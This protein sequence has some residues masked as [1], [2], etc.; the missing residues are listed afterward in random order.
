MQ[1]CLTFIILF[2]VLFPL[3]AL[4]LTNTGNNFTMLDAT[5]FSAATRLRSSVP[6]TNP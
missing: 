5:G 2:F 3:N 6:R 4:A 1:R